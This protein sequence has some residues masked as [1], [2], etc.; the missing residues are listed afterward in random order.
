MLAVRNFN[1]R[2]PLHLVFEVAGWRIV[3]AYIRKNACTAFKRYLV[4]D[5]LLLN[6]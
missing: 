2:G 6:R 1:Y 5:R 4:T 3:Y